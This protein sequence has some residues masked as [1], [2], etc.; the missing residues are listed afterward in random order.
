MLANYVTLTNLCIWKVVVISLCAVHVIMYVV[1][2]I[3]CDRMRL[4]TSKLCYTGQLVYMESSSDFTVYC[5][6]NHVRSM[7]DSM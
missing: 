7:D 4:Y 5:A 1:W 3:L 2:M 6:C